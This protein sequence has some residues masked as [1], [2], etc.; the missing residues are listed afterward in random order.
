MSVPLVVRSLLILPI[1]DITYICA[2]KHFLRGQ[3]MDDFD[4]V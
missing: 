1:V 2:Y 3:Y 4:N